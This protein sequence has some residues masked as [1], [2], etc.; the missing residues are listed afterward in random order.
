[1]H[2]I[3][4]FLRKETVEFLRTW[5][6]WV[7]G[8]FL[9]FFA[10]SSPLLAKM[11]PEILASV[12][13][14]QPGL[15]IKIPDPTWRDAYAQWIKNLSQIGTMIVIVVA[16][17]SVAS[18]VTS[19]TAQ[20]VLAKPVSRAGFVVAKFVALALYVAVLGALGTAVVQAETYAVFGSAPAAELW[21]S[22]GLW[23]AGALLL[24]AVA[25]LASTAMP[26]LA[27]VGV[28]MLAFL[29]LPVAAIWPDAASYSPAGLIGM[30]ARV[31]T[32]AQVDMGWPLATSVAVA[33]V[34]LT[35]ACGVF[36]RREL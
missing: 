27:A 33:I 8:G 1:M 14:G 25:V 32:G 16:A 31:V 12:G 30:P 23:L 5:R 18:E 2:G 15:V 17:G 11:T 19:G 34:V 21:R 9:I 7:L 29:L 20:L 22:S 28:S 35:A 26:T 10:L 6:I 13:T 4:G 36:S 24:S 3:R